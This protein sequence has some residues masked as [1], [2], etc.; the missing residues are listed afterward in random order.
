MNKILMFAILILFYSC[1]IME[2]YHDLQ[3]TGYKIAFENK[4]LYYHPDFKTLRTLD[5][6]CDYVDY[7]IRYEDGKSY[8]QPETT[9]TTREGN[10]T[11]IS[12]AFVNTLYLTTDIKANCIGVGEYFNR[13][14]VNGGTPD[15]CI[16]ELEDGTQIEPQT[17][18]I[19]EDR[20]IVRYRYTFDDIFGDSIDNI[21]GLE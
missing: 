9:L 16:V 17:G 8:Q 4:Q 18:E 19:I 10:C 14:V 5:N 3:D 20:Y 13:D 11:S 12:I 21:K 1:N 7:I 15:H 6:V 2:T